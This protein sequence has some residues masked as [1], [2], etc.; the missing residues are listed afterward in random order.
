MS[1]VSYEAARRER[2]RELDGFRGIAALG[3][4]ATHFTNNYE[5]LYPNLP[6]MPFLATYGPI[7]VQLFFLISG[8]VILMSALRAARPSD[9]V[10]SRASRLYPTYW[11]AVTLS[12]ILTVVTRFPD[13][14]MSWGARLANYTMFQRWFLVP[15]VDDVYWTLAV[16][17]QFYVL[18]FL[19]LVVT[20]AKLSEKTI[21]FFTAAWCLVAL[22]LAFWGYGYAHGIDPQ[23]VAT[24]A[25]IVLNLGLVEWAP[26]FSCGM[27][28]FLGRTR[29]RRY[30]RLAL[31][32]AAQAVLEAFLLHDAQTATAVAVVVACFLVVVARKRTRLLLLAPIQFYGKISYSLYIQ[33]SIPGLLLLGALAPIIGTWLSLLVALLLVTVLATGL[34]LVGEEWASRHFKALLKNLQLRLLGP[35]PERKEARA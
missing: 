15:N 18:I 24:K 7:G 34:H 23:N 25:K 16:E 3:V 31:L 33:H 20:K 8:Y 1:A 28:A 12:I 35:G 10:V 29:D 11:I 32:F 13:S 2:F 6:K 30:F 26:L 4:V 14:D 5:S 22:P 17:M 19:L 27:M 21:V 9:F